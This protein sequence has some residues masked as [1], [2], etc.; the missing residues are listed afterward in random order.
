MRCVAGFGLGRPT[1]DLLVRRGFNCW[2]WPAVRGRAAR[3][4][5]QAG[6]TKPD[7]PTVPSQQ[8]GG[9]K[10]QGTPVGGPTNERTRRQARKR[11]GAGANKA[12]KRRKQTETPHQK[13]DRAKP[14]GAR[15]RFQ[16]LIQDS[17]FRFKIHIS[18]SDR[19][20]RFQIQTSDLRSRFQIS[21]S[22]FRFRLPCQISDSRFRFPIQDSDFRFRLQIQ[23]WLFLLFCCF[24]VV[25]CLLFVCLCYW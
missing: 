19:R 22:G 9:R 2:L 5:T 11:A 6:R 3:I 14:T 7:K 4:A 12:R 16:I 18:D 23:I 8:T 20:C 25:G 17:D 15:F 13:K 1:L 21:D 10:K 24:V